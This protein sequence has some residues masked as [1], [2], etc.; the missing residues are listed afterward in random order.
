MKY[1]YEFIGTFFL[2]F[3]VGMTLFNPSA[4]LAPLAI[5][6]VLAALVFAGGYVCSAHYN[7]AISL[8]AFLAC[9]LSL[10]DLVR[11]II[12]QVAAAFAASYL[13]LFLRGSSDTAVGYD[14]L[15][16]FIAEF[17]FI[18]ALCFV[19]LNVSAS[20]STAGNSYFGL[21]IGLIVFVGVY[22]IGDI[23]GGA[24]NPA[25]AVGITVLGV[26]FWTNLWVYIVAGIAGAALAA[27]IFNCV[28]RCVRKRDVVS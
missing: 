16:I 10:T 12:V 8:A 5:G 19:A 28:R 7:P 21:A 15:S 1:I 9:K 26:S 14:M 23:S 18:F 22:I 27:A 4:T 24:L 2:V 6:A 20:K 13:V 11:Y 25:V 17:L 3:T